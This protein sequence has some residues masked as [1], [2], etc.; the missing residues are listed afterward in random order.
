MLL[1][2]NATWL[3]SSLND[4]RDSKMEKYRRCMVRQ[5]WLKLFTKWKG[6]SFY[7]VCGGVGVLFLVLCMCTLSCIAIDNLGQ[8]GVFL[9]SRPNE[10][11]PQWRYKNIYDLKNSVIVTSLKC[12]IYCLQLIYTC[13][14]LW[15][16]DRFLATNTF[17]NFSGFAFLAAFGFDLVCLWQCF[18]VYIHKLLNWKRIQTA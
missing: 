15:G 10:C 16:R 6:L 9:C 8:G 3:V 12:K 2:E 13:N 7:R 1:I 5:K 14:F 17:I 18:V 4:S 11:L